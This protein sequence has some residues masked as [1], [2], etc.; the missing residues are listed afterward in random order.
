MHIICLINYR[1][2]SIEPVT[3]KENI[4]VHKKTGYD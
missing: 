2:R 4:P 1:L 3:S